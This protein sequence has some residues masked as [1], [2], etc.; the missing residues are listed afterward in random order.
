MAIERRGEGKRPTCEFINRRNA[1]LQEKFKADL[2]DNL[3][4][5]RKRRK[6]HPIK[7]T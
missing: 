4:V 5:H 1:R 6:N 7:D 3:T 2:R